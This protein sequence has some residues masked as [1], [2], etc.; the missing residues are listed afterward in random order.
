MR[1]I[2][3][4]A[5]LSIQVCA[6]ETSIRHAARSGDGAPERNTC[7]APNCTDP[8]ARGSYPSEP[9]FDF[10]VFVAQLAGHGAVDCTPVSVEVP[11]DA[12]RGVEECTRMAA[13]ATQPWFFEV[14]DEDVVIGPAQ[15]GQLLLR[16]G[17][18][19]DHLRPGCGFDTPP[20]RWVWG[21]H[22]SKCSAFSEPSR[23]GFR[24]CESFG[25]ENWLY[26]RDHVVRPGEEVD[27]PLNL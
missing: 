1:P 13:L 24:R 19:R 22:W 14:L 21:V 8:T 25:A 10:R 26:F 11:E 27:F 3:V 2:A 5:L 12:I 6:Q 7:T 23:P 15:G 16:H 17:R 18:I 4:I 9:P 20:S